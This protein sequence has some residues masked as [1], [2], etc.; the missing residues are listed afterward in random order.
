MINKPFMRIYVVVAYLLLQTTKTVH[1]IS[2]PP[3]TQHS[4]TEAASNDS[5]RWA[6]REQ[7]WNMSGDIL[8]FPHNQIKKKSL[9]GD[10]SGFKETDSLQSY[11]YESEESKEDDK[12]DQLDDGDSKWN[13]L[14]PDSPTNAGLDEQTMADKEDRIRQELTEYQCSLINNKRELINL[15]RVRVINERNRLKNN[16]LEQLKKQKENLKAS[17]R[18]MKEHHN[19]AEK[20]KYDAYQHKHPMSSTNDD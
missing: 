16:L 4:H 12:L 2:L 18:E 8:L 6:E 3:T 10:D 11:S 15:E 7:L 9:S 5:G 13:F 19:L 17:L 1:L 14:K 20:A